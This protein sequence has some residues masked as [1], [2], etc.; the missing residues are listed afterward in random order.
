MSDIVLSK[1]I[2]GNLLSLMGT[3]D[4]RDRTQ[5]RLSTGKKVNTALDNPGNFFSAA[6]LNSRA[7]DITNLLDGIG[8]AIKTLEAADNGIRSIVRVVE[9]AQAL[10]RQAQGSAAT[11]ARLGGV[12]PTVNGL[13]GALTPQT[14]LTTLGFAA[15]ETI[16]INTGTNRQTVLTIAAGMTVGNLVDAINNNTEATSATG[17]G[18]TIG[19]TAGADAR[20]LLSPDGRLV[21][22]AIGTQPLTLSSSNAGSALTNMGF[23]PADRAK[24][25]GE[26]NVTRSNIAAQFSELRRQIDQLAKDSGFNGVNLLN[27]DTLQAMFN[28]RQTSSLTI[29]G[30]R[31]SVDQDLAIKDQKNRFQTDADINDALGELSQAMSMLRS[32]S[33]A[34]G[35]NLALVQIRQKFTQEMANTLKTGADNLVLADMNEEG[36][37]MLALQTRQ[38]LSTQA[39]SLA[40]QADQSV[41]RLFGG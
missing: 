3:A 20:A 4:L 24:L 16:T 12:L 32:Q 13:V 8:T 5:Y 15:G 10:A 14:D 25:A 27:A 18:V 30:V 7:T 31:F 2:R 40:N 9:N 34:F 26:I 33:S 38:Q 21:I 36:A 22:Q 37:N 11:T 6:M 29:T 35:S 41:L 17:T 39:L 23:A 19:S 1:G 28:E